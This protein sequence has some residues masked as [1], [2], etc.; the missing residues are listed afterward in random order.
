MTSRYFP[1]SLGTLQI[2]TD[3]RGADHGGNPFTI[4]VAA[5]GKAF[6]HVLD[7]FA[8]EVV[9]REMD[10][11]SDFIAYLRDRERF[12]ASDMSVVAAGEEQLVALL[13]TEWQRTRSELS[14]AFGEGQATRYGRIR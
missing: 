6:V 1:G 14:A 4:G 7:E 11:A 8:L 10:T 3:I 5:P 13:F 12:L 2:R 9:L